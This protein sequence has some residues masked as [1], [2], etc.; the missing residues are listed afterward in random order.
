[1]APRRRVTRELTLAAFLKPFPLWGDRQVRVAIP[2]LWVSMVGYA[3]YN[4]YVW[5]AALHQWDM[6]L[7]TGLLALLLGLVYVRHIDEWFEMTVRRLVDR[8]AIAMNEGGASDLLERINRSATLWARAMALAAALALGVAFFMSLLE[9]FRPEKALLMIP[10]VL[11]AYLAGSYL[12]RMASYGRLGRVLHDRGVELHLRPDHVDGAAGLKP[13]GDFY[14]RQAMVAAIPVAFL[15]IWVVLFPF[16]D[17]YA[18]WGRPYLFL[19]V[20]ALALELLAFIAPMLSFHRAMMSKKNQLLSEADRISREIE[21]LRA[22][23]IESDAGADARSARVEVLKTRYWA[24][25]NMPV[26]PVDLSTRRRFGRANLILALPLVTRFVDD[27]VPFG[28]TL[29]ALLKQLSESG[30]N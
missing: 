2:L 9:D 7:I 20:V 16:W 26:W 27:H 23:P 17:R 29:R 3:G 19:L 8:R 10:E 11:G 1:M 21:T 25:E 28:P 6:L 15:G 4:L 14:F 30:P 5:R 24:I 12:G 22:T 18:D 13:V